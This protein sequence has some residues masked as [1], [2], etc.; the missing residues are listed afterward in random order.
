MMYSIQIIKLV[1]DDKRVYSVDYEYRGES[2]PDNVIK[3]SSHTVNFDIPVEY[4][5]EQLTANDVVEWILP[6]M[7]VEALQKE[8]LELF[9]QDRERLQ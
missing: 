8:I 3:K 2:D 6:Y 4:V 9:Q 7:N 1:M 5:K